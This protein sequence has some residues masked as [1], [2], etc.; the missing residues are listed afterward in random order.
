MVSVERSHLIK[1][2]LTQGCTV[3]RLLGRSQE[4]GQVG[5]RACFLRRLL[6][7]GNVAQDKVSLAC[8]CTITCL[9]SS[10]TLVPFRFE[11]GG[12]EGS[13][14]QTPNTATERHRDRILPFPPFPHTHCPSIFFI[15]SFY[16]IKNR[17]NTR[18]Q[19]HYAVCASERRLISAHCRAEEETERLFQTKKRA[20]QITKT[21]KTITS[22]PPP[23][24]GV[25]FFNSWVSVAV[26]ECI[27]IPI[28]TVK[29]R[30][31]LQGE[32]GAKKQ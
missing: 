17:C 27:T 2:C 15:S 9:W 11:T 23:S 8:A 32:L 5:R 25:D 29:V 4:G 3:Q 26:A 24:P 16:R 14:M 30:L 7:L 1:K 18:Q 28:D 12:G 19:L 22:N 31:M 6:M 20:N 21:S 10:V 13:V